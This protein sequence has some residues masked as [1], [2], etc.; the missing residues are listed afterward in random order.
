MFSIIIPTF[1]NVEYLKLCISSIEKNSKFEHEIIPHINIGDDGTEEFLKNKNIKY[2]ITNYNAGI[3]E[4]MN[5]A[6]KIATSNYILYAHDDFYFCPDWDEI[7]LNEVKKIKHNKFYLSGIMLNNGPIK[8]NCG[9]E[10]KDFDEEKLLKD[11]KMA[12]HYDFQGSTWAP[13]LIHKDLWDKVGG[14]SE[15]YFPGTGSDPD[16]NMKLWKEGV[17]IFKGINNFKVYHFGSI[18]TRKYKNHPTIKTESGSRG[19]KIF[20]IKWRISISFFKEF[21][22]K[23]DKIYEGELSNPRKT[24]RFL[25]KLLLCKINYFYIRYLYNFRNRHK[26]IIK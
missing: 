26:L 4:G 21:F 16:L 14:F 19:A 20:L 23:S 22:L 10:L 11:Y 2:T 7:L 9:N 25:F 1:N 18:V 6:S 24:M 5:K 17:R 3:C 12:N 13:H 15:E 8:F